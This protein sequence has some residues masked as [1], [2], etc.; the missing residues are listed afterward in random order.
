MTNADASEG[1]PGTSGAMA[2]KYA[3]FAVVGLVV[4]GLDQLG[5][6]HVAEALALGER[7]PVLGSLLA[8]AHEPSAGGALGLL[9]AWSPTAQLAAYALLS[10]IALLLALVFLRSLAPR[11]RGTAAAL[12]AVFGGVASNGL[13]RLRGGTTVDFLHLG[14]TSSTLLPDFSLADLAILLG[15]GTL[16]VELLATEMAAR[17]AERPRR[18]P[19]Y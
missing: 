4:I 2:V 1:A 12:G 3:A 18:S 10:G 5:K 17:A 6:R 19:P 11:D 16:I 7:V 14:P 13:D 9:R 8:F 15:V